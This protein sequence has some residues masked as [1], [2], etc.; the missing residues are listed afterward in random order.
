MITDIC[1]MYIVLAAATKVEIQATID[2]LESNVFRLGRHD[3]SVLVT[4]VGSIAATYSLTRQ[5]AVRR[6]SLVIQAGIAGCFTHLAPGGVVAVREEALGDLGVWEDGSFRTLFDL[7]L[8]DG[9]TPPFS[10]GYLVNPHEKLLAFS[11]LEQ[12]RSITVNEIT[13]RQ[14]RIGWYQQNLQ[15]VVESMEGG[16]L[17][18]VCLREDIGFLQLRAVSNEIGERDKTKWN[19]KVAVTNLNDALISLLN[20]LAAKDESLLTKGN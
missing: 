17:H 6:P 5:I 10:D 13:T 4:G 16:A 8:A 11:G 12:I 14:D 9:S 2:F 3:I 7:R 15:P 18:Y 19:I 1:T 20:G